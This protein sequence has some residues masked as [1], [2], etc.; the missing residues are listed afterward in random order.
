MNSSKTLIKRTKL[1]TAAHLKVNAM[2][3]WISRLNDIEKERERLG[4]LVREL[5]VSWAE[6][7]PAPKPSW[8]VPFDDL[9]E[10]GKEADRVIGYGL[11]LEFNSEMTGERM[12]HERLKQTVSDLRS[13]LGD[14]LKNDEYLEGFNEA[15]LGNELRERARDAIGTYGT[16]KCALP[17]DANSPC[18][19]CSGYWTRMRNEGLWQ[20]GVGWTDAA[21]YPS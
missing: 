20:D 2:E 13:L 12:E 17:C 11:F 15:N 21:L 6:K 14:I 16:V 4:R 1:E 7:Q 10:Q 18:D 8:L 5:W 3:N 19:E 9:S